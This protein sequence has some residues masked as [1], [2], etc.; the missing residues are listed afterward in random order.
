MIGDEQSYGLKARDASPQANDDISEGAEPS[1]SDTSQAS[2]AESESSFMTSGPQV[3]PTI[4][5]PDLVSGTPS[6]QPPTITG[7]AARTCAR[8]SL[9]FVAIILVLMV[10]L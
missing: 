10:M 8:L 5:R 4:L 1:E 7:G 9:E 6:P 2:E 3:L